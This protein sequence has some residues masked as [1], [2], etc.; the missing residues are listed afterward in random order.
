[1]TYPCGPGPDPTKG[2]HRERKQGG[3]KEQ[4]RREDDDVDSGESTSDEELRVSPQEVEH[5]LS[6]GK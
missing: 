5:G 6:Q 3:Q 2:E 4:Q 1:V